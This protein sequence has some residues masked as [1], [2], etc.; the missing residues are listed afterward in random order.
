MVSI[1]ESKY[2]MDD[3]IVISIYHWD[4]LWKPN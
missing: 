1:L 4:D 3:L 2:Q